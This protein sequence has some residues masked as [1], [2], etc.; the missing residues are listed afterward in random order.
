MCG[1]V[2]LIGRSSLQFREQCQLQL[3]SD[4]M[5]HRGPDGEGRFEADQL[6]MAM[7][8]LSIID[9]TG[10]WQPLYNEDQSIALIANGEVYNYIE[11]RKDLEA[12]GHVFRTKGD[13]ET[14]AHLYE[15]YGDQVVDK[16][17]GMYAFALY[18]KRRNRVLLAR[19]RMGE[20]PLYLVETK[21]CLYFSS[22][23]RCLIRAGIVPFDLDP[24]GVFEYFHYQ[25]VPEP[26][27]TVRGIRKLPAGHLL[28]VELGDFSIRQKCY[29]R[30][31]DAPP[32]EGDPAKIVRA[33]L[34]RVSELIVRSDVPVG[35]A[36]S[37]GVDSSAI[38]ALA[39]KNYPGLLQ[40]F[41]VGYEGSP[42]QDERIAARQFAEHIRMPLHTVELR[43]EEVVDDFPNMVFL[44]DDPIADISGTGYLAVMRAARDKGVRVMLM[45]H[46]GDELFWGY[47]WV[48]QALARSAL[49]QGLHANPSTTRLRDYLQLT[50]PPRSLPLSLRWA[51]NGAGLISGYRNYVQDRSS[52]ADRLVHYDHS[53]EFERARQQLINVMT[54]TFVEHLSTFDATE[55]FAVDLPWKDLPVHIARLTCQTYLLEN[56]LAQGDRLSMAASVELR[57]PLVDYRFV[58]TAIGLMK[59]NPTTNPTPKKWLREAVK[60]VVPDFVMNR[61]KTGF[62]APWKRWVPMMQNRYGHMV[63]DGILVQSGVLR[64]GVPSTRSGFLALTLEVWC[65]Q[66]R[67][68]ASSRPA[69]MST[70]AALVNN[71]RRTVRE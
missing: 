6:F 20:K 28:T 52:P 1:I 14:I 61:P 46:G 70:V 59:A 30:M 19:D 5:I 8:R 27:T 26:R 51:R 47:W 57:V 37:S 16:L 3:L 21:D 36:L 63:E 69:E 34:E 29:W 10:G 7:R 17:R 45:G 54:P 25:Y 15:E 71:R 64:R 24:V 23:L 50:K 67:A 2:G 13:C 49:K 48:R 65:R 58:E 60:D 32:L 12:R 39:Q 33:E 66:M 62:N 35:I 9:L 31:E 56:G 4:A 18:D 41:T 42:R 11:L 68:A 53:F 38:A 43:D 44:R 22:E 40:G 55:R